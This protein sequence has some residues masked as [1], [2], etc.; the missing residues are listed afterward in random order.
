MD[1][2]VSVQMCPNDTGAHSNVSK[3][4]SDTREQLE[5]DILAHYKTPE[6]KLK[7]VREWLDRQA[8]ITKRKCQYEIDAVAYD[9]DYFRKHVWQMNEFIAELT[10]ER[11]A[12]KEQINRFNASKSEENAEN[13][14]S[15]G[16]LNNFDVQNDT[17]EQLEADIRAWHRD[18][19]FATKPRV[20][21]LLG[22]L[23]RQAAITEREIA[24]RREEYG[25]LPCGGT[26]CMELVNELQAK[27]DELKERIAELTAEVEKHRKRAN[28]A[29]RGV[30]SDEWYV[31]RDRYE[32]D[33]AELTSERD[34]FRKHVNHLMALIADIAR[35]QP[36]TFDPEA[37]YMTLDTIGD[38][39]DELHGDVASMRA[40][41]DELRHA[42][43]TLRASVAGLK[44]TVERL[45][46]REPADMGN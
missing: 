44:M 4:L 37:P 8:A 41:R 29:E 6:E 27:R 11:D 39:I 13:D 18:T 7:T 30:L 31:A 36:Y 46:G 1:N 45:T 9:R 40:E 5:A 33:I 43:N 38:Y 28:D 42:N 10:A 16:V 22:W 35:K 3:S 21:T 17:R 12:L 2:G 20:Q 19:P 15:K 24:E 34:H 14:T 23:D 26:D 25:K 32:D